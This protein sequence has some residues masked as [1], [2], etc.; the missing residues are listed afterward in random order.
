VGTSAAGLLDLRYDAC[1]EYLCWSEIHANILS[2]LLDQTITVT[3]N[4]YCWR[5]RPGNVIILLILAVLI[6]RV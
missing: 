4:V 3:F 2:G 6:F 5:Q 1:A